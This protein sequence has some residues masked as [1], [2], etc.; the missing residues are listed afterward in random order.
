MSKLLQLITAISITAFSPALASNSPFYEMGLQDVNVNRLIVKELDGKSANALYAVSKKSRELVAERK[1]IKFN[2]HRSSSS[3]S[4]RNLFE[5]LEKNTDLKSLD[6]TDFAYVALFE[7][8]RVDCQS[9]ELI[10]Q[11]LKDLYQKLSLCPELEVLTL[12]NNDVEY[13]IRDFEI[14]E[15]VKLFPK[16][17]ILN[18]VNCGY[19][20]D[21]SILPIMEANPALQ[22]ARYRDGQD[23]RNRG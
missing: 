12:G 7:Y 15:I 4:F 8:Y 1:H 13:I 2:S 21:E 11:A 20:T 14:Q 16:L 9:Q 5:L 17:T 6:I 23:V 3:D 22:I 10:N 19:V 18:L